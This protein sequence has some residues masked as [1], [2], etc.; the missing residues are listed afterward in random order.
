MS[1]GAKVGMFSH[2]VETTEMVSYSRFLKNVYADA[3][4]KKSCAKKIST[5]FIFL[6]PVL[7]CTYAICM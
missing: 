2:Y 7:M 1:G 4:E 6:H 5:S 3:M